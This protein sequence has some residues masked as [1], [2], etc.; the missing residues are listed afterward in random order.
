MAQSSEKDDWKS[1]DAYLA[2]EL[3]RTANSEVDFDW[4][5]RANASAGLPAI[6]VSPLQGKFLNLLVKLSGARRV[7][8]IGTLGGYS[9]AWLSSA[10][11]SNGTLTTIDIDAN[12]VGVA[13]S[14]LSQAGLSDRVN[15]R[16]GSATKILDEMLSDEIEPFDFVFIDA[17]KPSGE[18][19]FSAAMKLTRSGS[20]IVCDNVVRGGGITD[21]D[22]QDPDIVGTQSLLS[23][24]S[25]ESA[26]EATAIQTV[27]LK[28]HDGFA[29]LRV[30]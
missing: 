24:I 28:G 23:A 8:E 3:L 26:V 6:D 7:L 17:D 4:I 14:N 9:T 18:I 1:V 25:A 29:I 22:A 15:F 21:N 12:H 5:L 2:N 11:P 19:Y 10:L 30:R 16:L 20:V 27:G 13:A